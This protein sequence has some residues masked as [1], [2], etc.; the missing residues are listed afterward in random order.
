MAVSVPICRPLI[1]CLPSDS[2]VA[3]VPEDRL[4]LAYPAAVA[5]PVSYSTRVATRMNPI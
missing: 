1:V 3:F 5:L 4:P 2:N